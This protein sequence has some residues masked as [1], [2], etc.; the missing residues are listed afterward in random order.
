MRTNWQLTAG[1]LSAE[2]CHEL[3]DF[4][5]NKLTLD[6]ASVFSGGGPEARQTKVGWTTDPKVLTLIE[7]YAL[8]ANREAFN[9]KVDFLPPVQFAEYGTGGHYDWHHDVHWESAGRYDRKLSVVIQLSDPTQYQGGE[10]QFREVE[11]PLA[12]K[13]QGSILVFPS[14]L[15]H[16]VTPIEN[17]TRHS[18]VGWMEGPHWA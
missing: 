13:Q 18:L 12:F 6:D 16:R 9:F 5:K 4:C 15:L 17:G 14:Y 8:K 10:F 2:V 3:V 7:N 1:I 11:T